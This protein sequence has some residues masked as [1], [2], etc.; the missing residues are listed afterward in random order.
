MRR[1]AIALLL[2]III[3]C[4]LYLLAA[5]VSS[6]A[7]DSVLTYSTAF[8]SDNGF[9]NDTAANPQ[10][11]QFALTGRY[12][13]ATNTLRISRGTQPQNSADA[14]L[15]VT[16]A[17]DRFHGVVGE[18]GVVPTPTS[19]SSSTKIAHRKPPLSPESDTTP[20]QQHQKSL[21]LQDDDL[22][23]TYQLVRGHRFSYHAMGNTTIQYACRNATT[24]EVMDDRMDLPPSTN[25]NSNPFD[26]QFV[27]QTSLN[28][29]IMGDSLAVQCGSWLQVAGGGRSNKTILHWLDWKS[30]GLVEGMAVATVN[31]GGSIAYWRLMNFWRPNGMK[32]R[33][34]QRGR[35]WRKP[36]VSHLQTMLP[37]P[38]DKY[39][40]IVFRISHP[41]IP[42]HE[43]T[44]EAL[45]ETIQTAREH[46]GQPLIFIFQTAPF[47]NNV[48]TET[49]L[50]EFRAMNNLV[51]SF[52]TNLNASDVLLS[53]VATYMENVMEW[54]AKQLGI[55]P[56]NTTTPTATTTTTQ[57]STNSSYVLDRLAVPPPHLGMSAPRFR[58]HVA[59][60]CSE[61]PPPSQNYT[62]RFNMLSN[63]GM[64]PCMESLGPRMFANTACLIQCAYNDTRE[65]SSTGSNS[66]PVDIRE[67]E[68]GCNERFFRLDQPLLGVI[69]SLTNNEMP[70]I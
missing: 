8:A 18:D 26:F 16:V 67:C 31:G 19:S 13:T 53:D 22:P 5:A 2:L 40:V 37:S 7:F 52:V 49:D 20:S 46:L 29:L 48:V 4:T 50:I 15:H 38:S 44:D 12:S 63:D 54:N 56:R 17:S 33:L 59:Q 68:R 60:I 24:W 36:W 64:H 47:E 55:I 1:Q 11:I 3:I 43:V 35:G 30:D 51:R 66:S 69:N 25:N 27:F 42:I 23:I 65:T 39:N 41:W 58:A 9:V 32:L 70:I 34:R 21:I 61:P 10:T 28:I 62:C 6:E 45:N 57:T 14:L